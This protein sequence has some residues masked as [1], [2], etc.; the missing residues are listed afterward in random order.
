MLAVCSFVGGGGEGGF[1]VFERFGGFGV[2]AAELGCYAG[3][4]MEF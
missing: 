4:D 3:L 2:E 1:E